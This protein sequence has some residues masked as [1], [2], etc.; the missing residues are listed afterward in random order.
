MSCFKHGNVLKSHCQQ[1]NK[2]NSGNLKYMAQPT[3]S[4]GF[5]CDLF[6]PLPEAREERRKDP[7]SHLADYTETT[8]GAWDVFRVGN[9]IFS[10]LEVCVS[11]SHRFFNLFGK[12]KGVF[13]SAGVALSIPQLISNVNTLRRSITQFLTSQDLP[14][15]DALRTRKI[16][17][18]AKTSFVDSIN[19]TN[20]VAQ[21]ALFLDSAKVFVF[22]TVYLKVVDGVYNV[23]GAISD[24]VELVGEYFKLKQYQSPEAQP[25]NQAEAAKLEEKKTLA[26]ITIAK[27]VASLFLGII[28]FAPVA[29]AFFGVPFVATAYI[30]STA[31]VAVSTF[32]LTMK[33]TG[34][35][36]NKVIVDAPATI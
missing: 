7:L 26:W 23:T 1:L 36:Y 18:A 25:R 19:L 15:S 22:E 30:T 29:A 6:S 4:A 31:I 20:T 32:W 2:C 11:P 33:I 34:H 27:D 12:I 10:I 28:T 17:Q 9:H 16:A 35:F 21:I 24:G 8:D 14:Y 5:F 3:T 13:D